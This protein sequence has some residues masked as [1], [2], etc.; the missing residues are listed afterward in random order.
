L[1]QADAADE[2]NLESLAASYN[3]L[4][5][6]Y[7]PT[8]PAQARRLVERALSIQLD[9]VKQQPT[10]REYQSDLALS[11]NNLGAIHARS[12]DWRHAELCFR[13]AITIQQRL[14]SV[15]PLMTNYQRDLAASFNN[16]GMMQTSADSLADALS[17]FEQALEIQQDLVDAQ[18]LNVGLLSSLGGIHNNLGMLRLKLHEPAEASQSFARAIEFQREALTKAPGVARFR[19]SLSKHYYNQAVVLRQLD[20]P[21][22]A[23]AATVARRELWPNDPQRLLQISQHLVEISHE[24]PAG[25]SR[26]QYLDEATRT[27]HLAS[28]A[29][30]QAKRVPQTR[31]VDVMFQ[32][33]IPLETMIDSPASAEVEE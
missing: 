19:E 16:L 1:R 4:S 15:A 8:Q 22:E 11:Y 5:S 2:K 17:S 27:R 14:V 30:A 20:R 7:L 29:T 3:N 26:D 18:P 23:A 25:A 33:T 6:L 21:T 10:R 12:G 31:T 28:K 24:I 9:L 32:D 13:D